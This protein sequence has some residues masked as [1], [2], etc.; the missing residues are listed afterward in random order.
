MTVGAGQPFTTSAMLPRPSGLFSQIWRRLD[1]L[2][3]RKYSLLLFVP[4][5][6]M[7]LIFVGPPI[8]AVFVMSTYR[9]ELLKDLPTGFVGL[10]NISRMLA[11]P[12]FTDSIPRTA[13]FSIGSTL[14]TIPLAVVAA[15]LMNVRGRFSALIGISVLLP[16]TIA[17]VVTGF[18][19]RFM[20]QPSFGL[21]TQLVT[22]T[23]QHYGAIPWLQDTKT[24]MAIAVVA[25][26]WRTI[27]LLALILLAALRSIPDS[28]YRAAR[29]DGANAW[30]SFRHIT[31][32]AIRPTLLIA[33]VLN[34]IISLQVF[35]I[36][37]QLTKGGPGFETTTMAYYV[38]DAAFNYLSLGYSAMLAIVLL[39]V[40]VL[41]SGA[42]LVFR[43]KAP[44]VVETEDALQAKP[45]PLSSR[46]LVV[47]GSADPTPTSHVP[48]VR[49]S[50]RVIRRL[51]RPVAVAV[52]A[53]FLLWSLGPTLWIFVAS[54]EPEGSITSVPLHLTSGVSLS[55]YLVLLTNT[56]WLGSISVSVQVALA[57]TAIALVIGALA[58]YPLARLR[59]PGRNTILGLLILSQMVPAIVLVIPVLLIFNALK[60]TDTVMAL[61]LANVAFVLPLVIWI[62]KG[63]FEK[64]P[65]ALDAAARMDGCGRLG[66]LFKVTIP[67]ASAGIAATAVLLLISTWNEFLFAVVLGSHDAVTVT[68]RIGFIDSP[69][70][71]LAGE[72]PYDIQ[73]A[74][75]MVAVLP[76]L[77]L[78]ALFH[79]RIGS[80][81]TEG[82]MK[83]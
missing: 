6:L 58:A 66:A 10:H 45:G 78:V 35:D 8:V 22:L 46:K 37:F 67:A 34:V 11:D 16:W 55:H 44:R 74:A 81:L 57:T 3:E 5:A 39:I 28:L 82:Y 51:E 75:G 43:S 38:Y 15:L 29:M 25:S 63:V 31:F 9:I 83:G 54:L 27:P 12:Q 64:V 30:Q 41:F 60:L 62:L 20:F 65:R 77:V 80:A 23:G 32:P 26:S 50:S 53:L 33:T 24:A 14:L 13:A 70:Q 36:I 2:D 71:G 49:T 19:W 4:A 69:F 18:Y 47:A 56:D 68:R 73:A 72:P 59:L 21:A 48:R 76:C 61:I 7:F 52:A 1:R 17:P 42:A 79:R 40:I